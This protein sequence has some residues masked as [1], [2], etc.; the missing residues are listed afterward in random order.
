M[1]NK[2]FLRFSRNSPH[3]VEPEGSLPCSQQFPPVPI[4]SQKYPIHNFSSYFSK[5][6]FNIILPSISQYFNWSLY[7]RYPYQ[8]PVLIFPQRTKCP[9]L[10]H[11]LKSINLIVFEKKQKLPSS[12]ICNYL[13]FPII[14]SLSSLSIFLRAQFSNT[15]QRERPSFTHM[16]NNRTVGNSLHLNPHVFI[17]QLGIKLNYG[18]P[19]SLPS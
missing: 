17:Q 9:R 10:Y 1:R 4:L 2:S 16:E 11:L 3:F 14:S 5:M 12:S 8:T 7:L 13:H 18:N 6:H 19:L 15:F